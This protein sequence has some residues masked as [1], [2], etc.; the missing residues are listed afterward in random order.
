MRNKYSGY[1]NEQ[2][3]RIVNRNEYSKDATDKELLIEELT[4]RLEVRIAHD[5]LAE[6][7]EALGGTEYNG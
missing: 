1:T 3:I 2:L 6:P 5:R 7:K 4:L